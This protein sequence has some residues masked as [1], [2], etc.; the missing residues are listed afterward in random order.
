MKHCL[1]IHLWAYGCLFV[2]SLGN[3]HRI[4]HVKSPMGFAMEWSL[5]RS[6]FVH[7]FRDELRV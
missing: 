4:G 2:Q 6:V 7:R 5:G 3:I 1:V